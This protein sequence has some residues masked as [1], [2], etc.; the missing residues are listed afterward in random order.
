MKWQNLT[1]KQKSDALTTSD[2]YLHANGV[3]YAYPVSKEYGSHASDAMNY[4]MAGF[5]FNN[6]NIAFKNDNKPV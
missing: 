1:D 2:L 6:P 5:I 4:F 3:Y